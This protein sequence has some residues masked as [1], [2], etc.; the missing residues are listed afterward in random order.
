[1]SD[2][3]PP[4]QLS[5]EE[6]EN[7]FM[8]ACTLQEEQ[9]FKEALAIY[10]DLLAYIPD[11][12]LLHFNMGL[13]YFDLE[14]F[15]TAHLHYQAA[16]R[17][18]PED[19]DLYFN[20][21]LNLRRLGKLDE[22]LDAF[23]KCIE[24]GDRSADTLYNM[25]LT[26]QECRQHDE[27]ASLYKQVLEA[28]PGHLSSLNNY[29]YL[30]HQTGK[31]N[32][33]ESLYTKLLQ[34]NPSHSA[35]KH[36][37]NALKGTTTSSAP[38]DYVESVFDGYADHF[39][40]S[41][42]QELH[43]QTPTELWK[44]YCSHFPQ[45]QKSFCLDLGC[46]TG[47]AGLAFQ[48]ACSAIHGVDISE[49]ILLVAKEKQLYSS[50][51]KDD[52]L[53]YLENCDTSYDLIIAADVFTYMGDLTALFK[54]CRKRMA[55]RGLLIFSVEEGAGD[56]FSLKDTGRFGHPYAY[57][58]KLYQ[59]NELRL[60]AFEKSRLRKDRDEWIAGYLFILQK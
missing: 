26:H 13:A 21:G 12:P 57:I 39:E 33:A 8:Q 2:I 47:L 28:D 14:D 10:N 52:I 25:A 44:L 38:L 7:R 37:V 60:A 20:K 6:L 18:N 43:Y 55:P 42:L 36:M 22:A 27:A 51:I 40:E 17:G 19:P 58:E 50:L 31:L 16:S 15:E 53:N 59:S 49:K 41:L 5:A 4:Q 34:I 56:S 48:S 1:M 29:A 35:A 46:G 24:L 30:C 45:S 32:E 54:A 23:S 9:H 3:N 11:S